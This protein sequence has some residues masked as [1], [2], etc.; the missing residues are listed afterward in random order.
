MAMAFAAQAFFF[1]MVGIHATVQQNVGVVLGMTVVSIV[2]SYVIRRVFNSEFWI[3]WRQSFQIWW[4]LHKPSIV[5]FIDDMAE[6]HN[7]WRSGRRF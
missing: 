1:N 6:A 4:L 3:G 2:R 5:K 7:K